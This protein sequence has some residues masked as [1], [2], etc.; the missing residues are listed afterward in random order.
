MVREGS[1]QSPCSKPCTP[2]LRGRLRV[3]FQHSPPDGCAW[4]DGCLVPLVCQCGDVRH[5]AA[6]TRLPYSPHVLTLPNPVTEDEKKAGMLGTLV[7][8]SCRHA[9]YT[10]RVWDIIGRS[11]VLYQSCCQ[12]LQSEKDAVACAVIARSSLRGAHG[13]R[14]LCSCGGTV[15]WQPSSQICSCKICK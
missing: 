2:K 10:S 6:S 14:Q 8:D 1:S 12:N 15:I 5:G 13:G 4:M 3:S 11:V 7:A 9:E